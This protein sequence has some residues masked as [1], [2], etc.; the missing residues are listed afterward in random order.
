MDEE[1]FEI[2]S[3]QIEVELKEAKKLV[4]FLNAQIPKIK[5]AIKETDF[6]NFLRKCEN[7]KC[8]RLDSRNYWFFCKHPE[9]KGK[10]EELYIPEWLNEI[11]TEITGECNIKNCPII[12]LDRRKKAK[13]MS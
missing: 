1:L 13:D 9:N 5:K 7:R 8:I 4:S 10:I 11:R 6:R 3:I 2:K 12:L